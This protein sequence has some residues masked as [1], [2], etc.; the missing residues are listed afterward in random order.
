ML[1]EFLSYENKGVLNSEEF[2]HLSLKCFEF[3]GMYVMHFLCLA[4][5]TSSQVFNFS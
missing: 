2:N 1:E 5:R 4:I 3:L